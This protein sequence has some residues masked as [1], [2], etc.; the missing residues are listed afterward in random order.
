MICFNKVIVS[1]E[2]FLTLVFMYG[3]QKTLLTKFL[4]DVCFKSNRIRPTI[5]YIGNTGFPNGKREQITK[6]YFLEDKSITV[7]QK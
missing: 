3:F 5:L 4:Y 6:E 7:D 2:S 1:L